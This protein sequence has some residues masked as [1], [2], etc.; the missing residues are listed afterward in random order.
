MVAHR[1][2][3]LQVDMVLHTVAA[4][5]AGRRTAAALATAAGARAAHRTA[6]GTAAQA[7]AAA[8]QVRSDTANRSVIITPLCS[9]P[10][11][12]G[13]SSYGSGPSG[14]D[15]YER[16]GGRGGGRGEHRRDGMVCVCVARCADACNR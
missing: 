11:Y 4:A 10:S 1:M 3:D 6:V 16:D 9:A 14:G 7:M 2:T 5:E 12:G 15:R 13:G 8:M